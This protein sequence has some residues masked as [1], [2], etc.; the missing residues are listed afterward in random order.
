MHFHMANAENNFANALN[1]AILNLP[2]HPSVDT[3]S[4][5]AW[6]PA[7]INHF[8]GH[9][10]LCIQIKDMIYLLKRWS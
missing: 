6:T 4:L 2:L 1:Y 3:I 10:Q 9:I 7:P 8:W 5:S